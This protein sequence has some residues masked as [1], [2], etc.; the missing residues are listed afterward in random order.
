M[1]PNFVA[2]N[3]AVSTAV[4]QRIEKFARRPVLVLPSGINVAKYR[5]GSIDSRSGLLYVGRITHHKNLPLLIDVFEE[6]CS[7]GYREVLKI[8]GTGPAVETVRR[9]IQRSPVAAKIQ[10]L[11]LV[12]DDLKCELLATSKLL[13]LTS[14]REGFPRVVAE[15][16]ASGLPVVTARY[17]QNGTAGIVEE[18]EC[19]VCAEPTASDLAAAA[20]RVLGDWETWSARTSLSTLRLDWTSIAAQFE[21]LLSKTAAAASNANLCLETEGVS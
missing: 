20:Q 16:I 17:P 14:W 3:T 19:G 9:R 21:S 7:R 13:I 2:A 12:S 10:M 11:G 8:A 18:F 4:A 1:L 6:L 15:A 5:A